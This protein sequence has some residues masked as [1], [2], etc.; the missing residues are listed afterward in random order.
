[1][2]EGQCLEG[3]P[4]VEGPRASPVMLG[5]VIQTEGAVAGG[6][7]LD[8]HH[9]FPE[10]MC[11]PGR[12]TVEPACQGGDATEQSDDRRCPG[13]GFHLFEGDRRLETEEELGPLGGF[14]DVPRFRLGTGLRV[15][16]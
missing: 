3:F 6:L 1:M 4:Q 10:R 13:S 15:V 7:D 8:H 2:T 5:P 14:D 12:Q 16:A 9:P 11:Q